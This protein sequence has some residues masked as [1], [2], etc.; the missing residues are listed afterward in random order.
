MKN[1]QFVR[2]LNSKLFETNFSC[3]KY[4]RSRLGLFYS[5]ELHVADKLVWFNFSISVDCRFPYSIHWYFACMYEIP[6][7][8]EGLWPLKQLSRQVNRGDLHKL[9]LIPDPIVKARS[10]SL[11]TWLVHEIRSLVTLWREIYLTLLKKETDGGKDDYWKK[12]D[13]KLVTF[14]FLATISC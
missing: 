4:Y 1:L 3:V 6:K 12:K 8:L 5:T 9:Q 11:G 14:L 7:S 13:F 10:C 2:K